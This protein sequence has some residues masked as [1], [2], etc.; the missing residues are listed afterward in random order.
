[1]TKPKRWSI[2]V[3]ATAEADI[4]SILRWTE[5]HF[6]RA[7]ARTYSRTLSDAIAAIAKDGPGAAGA[8]ARDDIDRGLFSL[9]VARRGRRGRHLL[10]FRVST[11]PA[12]ARTIDLLRVLHDA[13]DLPRHFPGSDEVD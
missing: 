12:S 8:R 13:M 2:R 1:V 5:R 10:L 6:G 11:T 9:H 7:Q 3:A 4:A